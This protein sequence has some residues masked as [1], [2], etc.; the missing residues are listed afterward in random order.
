MSGITPFDVSQQRKV[1]F[2]SV[3]QEYLKLYD[4]IY[5]S[6]KES[7][8]K[9]LLYG[10]IG[11][12]HRV[13]DSKDSVELLKLYRRNGPQDMNVILPTSSRERFKE[14][15][16][17]QGWTPY[18]H[19]E[20]TMGDVAG[21]FFYESLVLKAYY[22][23]VPTFNHRINLS[24]EEEYS[25]SLTDLLLTKLQMHFPTDKDT[26]DIAAI[27]LLEERIDVNKV[28]LHARSDWGFWKDA[29]QNLANVRSLVGRLEMDNV[30]TKEELKRVI[31]VSTKLYGQL[32]NAKPH[33]ESNDPDEKYW[34]DF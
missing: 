14:V 9:I 8:A 5:S 4:R 13:K 22:M 26:A 15:V 20:R 33:H 30:K 27:L 19:L 17:E 28:L 18:Y 1:P 7:G 21:M 3:A 12:Y 32:M 2:E 6:L 29:T 31:A 25:A 24:W 34:L 23:D 11:I 10:S 16:K